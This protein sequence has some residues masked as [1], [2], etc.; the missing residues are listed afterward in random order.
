ML[1][2][3]GISTAVV[4]ELTTKRAAASS[5]GLILVLVEIS[6]APSQKVSFFLKSREAVFVWHKCRNSN[7][8]VQTVIVG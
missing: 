6:G 5:V 4:G 3:H 7:G 2:L 8:G 1:P